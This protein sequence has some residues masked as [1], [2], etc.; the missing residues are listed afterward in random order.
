MWLQWL[1]SHVS[2]TTYQYRLAHSC[3]YISLQSEF[4]TFASISWVVNCRTMNNVYNVFGESELGRQKDELHS[5]P[6]HLSGLLAAA[7]HVCFESPP[8]TA[9]VCSRNKLQFIATF[10]QFRLHSFSVVANGNSHPRPIF[11]VTA[12][13]GV[14]SGVWS[15]TRLQKLHF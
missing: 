7:G 11:K 4:K 9:P 1:I 13:S 8:R 14:N 10:S 15:S 12:R 3:Y 6:L 2:L 5:T